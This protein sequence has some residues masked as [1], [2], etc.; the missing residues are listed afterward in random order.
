[1]LVVTNFSIL[2]LLVGRFT[3]LSFE[4]AEV[5]SVAVFVIVVRDDA[6][7]G[8]DDFAVLNDNL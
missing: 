5:F 2:V 7:I 8:G 6:T 1:V 3:S 4:F